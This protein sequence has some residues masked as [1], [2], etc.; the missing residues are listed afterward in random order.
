MLCLELC[1]EHGNPV[2]GPAGNYILANIPGRNDSGVEDLLRVLLLLA[3]ELPRYRRTVLGN[4]VA[5]VRHTARQ[6]ATNG[7]WPGGEMGET[8]NTAMSVLAMT[9]SY[10]QLPIYQRNNSSDDNE[11]PAGPEQSRRS[12]LYNGPPMMVRK[13]DWLDVRKFGNPDFFGSVT[14]LAEKPA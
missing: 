12:V 11:K 10:R 4:V 3:G 5:D 7:G 1:G 6:P 2:I 8:Y 9:V 14:C 13:M